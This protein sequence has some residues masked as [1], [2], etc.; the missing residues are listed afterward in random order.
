MADIHKLI[1]SRI[2]VALLKILVLHPESAFNINELIRRTEFSPR[3]VEKELKNLLSAGILKRE[4]VGNQHR[5]QLDPR[6]AIHREVKGIIIKTV[7]IAMLLKQA[8]RS[9]EKE[10]DRAFIY[11]SFAK[12]DY[13][14]DSD[15][16]LF[17][18]TELSGLKLAELIGD[19]QNEIGR[20]INVSQFKSDE[21]NQR[22][23][24]KDHFLTRVLDGPKI[25]IIGGVDE[26]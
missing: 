11:G 22:K 2:R 23:K 18:V 12:G 10:I 26:S 9:V 17:V 21:F 15:V 14:N 6:C 24:Q 3:G 19:V 25:A 13:G 7:G 8:L 16:D 1:S 20:S 4:V 5:Y